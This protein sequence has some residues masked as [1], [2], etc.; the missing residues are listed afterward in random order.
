M[1]PGNPPGMLHDDAALTGPAHETIHRRA[2]LQIPRTV[3]DNPAVARVVEQMAQRQETIGLFHSKV[4]QFCAPQ[5][6]PISLVDSLFT[7]FRT[8]VDDPV[9]PRVKRTFVGQWYD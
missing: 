8:A 1:I 9:D 6:G 2:D 7:P 5:P 4:Q 3:S